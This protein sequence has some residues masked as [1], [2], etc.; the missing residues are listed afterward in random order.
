M[1]TNTNEYITD[2]PTFTFL[3][4]IAITIF[5]FST[6]K[7][8]AWFIQNK[9]VNNLTSQIQSQ[10]STESELTDSTLINPPDDK[11]NSYW[12]F[13][14]TPLMNVNFES[15]LKQNNDTVGWIKVENTNINYPIVQADDNDFYLNHSYDKQE[16]EAGWVFADYR[17]NMRNFNQ[18]TIIYGHSR[19]DQTIFGSLRNVTKIKWLE[20]KSN[21]VIHLSTPTKNTLWQVFSVY[22]IP[23][24]SYYLTTSF[25]NN[26]DYSTFLN[27]LASRSIYKFGV[28]LNTND[29]ILTLSTCTDTIEN[30]RIV[31]HAKLIKSES[32][33]SL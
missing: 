17:N 27:T 21:H 18:N 9:N 11:S 22:K 29:R 1:K 3:M 31:L 12:S 7:I 24:E 5:C 15:L 14:N 13:V 10:L 19:L 23:A 25:A 30:G 8:I 20:N 33:N 26:S 16:N 4:F 6:Y 28:S 32:K 2:K